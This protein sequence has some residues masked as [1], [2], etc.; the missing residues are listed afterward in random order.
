MAS[1]TG[2]LDTSLLS[3]GRQG[4]NKQQPANTDSTDPKAKRALKI[5][6][7]AAIFFSSLAFFTI[8]K[9]P[10][11]LVAN[12][13]LNNLNSQTPYQWQ[14]ERIGL[15]FFLT[16]HVYFEKL[17]LEPTQ[18]G[19]VPLALNE[20]RFYPNPFSLLPI[21]GPPALGGSFKADAYSSYFWGSFS[22]GTNLNLRLET[23][24]CDLAKL[25]PLSET[26][27]SLKGIASSVYVKL[28]LPN[29]RLSLADG[30]IDLKG[31]NLVFDPGPLSLPITLPILKLGDLEIKGSIN[32]GAFKIEK[33]QL[34]GAKGDLELQANGTITLADNST[35]TRVD[36]HLRVKPS[37]NLEKAVPTLPGLLDALGTKKPD[38][39][40]AFKMSGM[41]SQMGP[42]QKD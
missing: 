39:F 2:S 30:E 14:A 20:L 31:K 27:L 8:L 25:T 38:G 12:V 32:H 23:E 11:S 15:A 28:S 10:D 26:G 4:K 7:Y 17:N 35:L 36:L 41:V 1:N 19:G 22:S 24:D 16:P 13:A 18:P 21:G 3:T 40:Y 6:A 42:P 37:P 9:I 34:G 33:L 29:Q 5:A